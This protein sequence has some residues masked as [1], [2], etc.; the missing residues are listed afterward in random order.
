MPVV[1]LLVPT[2]HERSTLVNAWKRGGFPGSIHLELCGFGPIVAGIRTTQLIQT[3]HPQH[4]CLLGIAGSLASHAIVGEAYMFKQV[5]CY[6]VGVGCG[7]DFRPASSIEWSQWVDPPIRDAIPAKAI[8]TFVAAGQLVTTCSAS[9]D[10]ADAKQ[11]LT[12][13]PDAVA[14]DMEAFSVAAACA[15]AGIS[16]SCIR[17]ISNVAGDREKANW[18]VDQA[19]AAAA[20]LLSSVKAQ[21]P[22]L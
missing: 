16:F 14:E 13:F 11:K 4:V 1:L 12:T 19:L 7:E 22:L 10:M 21:L 15:L 6:G 9:T 2:E 18:Q 8:D 17:G 20:Q 5:A 3:H